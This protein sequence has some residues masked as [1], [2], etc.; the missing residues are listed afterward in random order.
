MEGKCTS[1]AVVLDTGMLS[2][3]GEFLS[4]R[5][6]FRIMLF[7]QS[8]TIVGRQHTWLRQWLFIQLLE[9]VSKSLKIPRLDLQR[10]DMKVGHEHVARGHYRPRLVPRIRT[11][12]M[13]E[14]IAPT[15]R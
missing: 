5:R 15:G 12:A 11:A 14:L 1:L 6:S 13:G 3:I 2:Q 4:R 7:R 8:Q 9:E 10:I